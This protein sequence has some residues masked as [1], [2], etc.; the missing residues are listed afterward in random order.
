MPSPPDLIQLSTNTRIN[1]NWLVK[2]Q[3]LKE[4]L[5][6]LPDDFIFKNFHED[7]IDDVIGPVSNNCTL[8]QKAFLHVV[9]E[10][11]YNYPTTYIS[12]K[13][14]K[15]IISKRPFIIVGPSGSVDNL[16]SIGFKTFGDFWSEEYDDILDPDERIMAIA[17]IIEWICSK[18]INDLRNLCVSMQD[19]LNYNFNFYVSQFKKNEY[20]K[21]TKFCIQ[22]VNLR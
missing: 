15:P 12:E 22:N 19:V 18:S 5:A 11:V 20:K 21:L 14:I 10:T 7:V 17:D 9:T 6:A 1:H 16:R 2:N 13:T 8:S 3:N 4:S